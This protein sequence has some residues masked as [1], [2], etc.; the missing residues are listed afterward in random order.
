M[1]AAPKKDGLAFNFKKMQSIQLDYLSRK[2]NAES[3]LM[4]KFRNY[5]KQRSVLEF[6]YAKNLQRLSQQFSV[7]NNLC[8]DLGFSNRSL[9]LAWNS[10]LEDNMKITQQHNNLSKFYEERVNDLSKYYASKAETAK[11]GLE[12]LMKLHHEIM[13]TVKDADKYRRDYVIG[14]ST[15]EGLKVKIDKYNKRKNSITLFKS[16][17][18]IEQIKEQCSSIER[19][20]C[21]ARNVHYS[22]EKISCT[23]RKICY[24]RFP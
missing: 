9:Y 3:D 16:D 24:C 6:D 21:S 5:Y 11:R 22:F 12:Q 2:V 15:Y 14:Q 1:E 23:I 7:N 4:N 20:K 18:D 19:Q 17:Q 8:N 10:Y 13:L